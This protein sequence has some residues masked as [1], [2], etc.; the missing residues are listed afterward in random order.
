MTYRLPTDQAQVL[1][2][3]SGEIK[4]GFFYNFTC[5]DDDDINDTM[6]AGFESYKD[7]RSHKVSQVEK[8]IYIDEVRI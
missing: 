3:V 5:Y 8:W 7:H 2:V 1:F 4:S 6:N